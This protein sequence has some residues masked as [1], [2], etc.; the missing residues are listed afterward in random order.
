MKT[1][2]NKIEI[3]NLSK[4]GRFV[5]LELSSNETLKIHYD[6]YLKLNSIFK[7]FISKN[8]LKKINY[9]EE[10]F[11]AKEKALLFLS[12]RDHSKKEIEIKLKKKNFSEKIIRIAINYLSEKKYLDDR[13]FA[14]K[15]FLH[16]IENTKKSRNK[17]RFDLLKK[18]IKGELIEYVFKK[19][20]SEENELKKAMDLV[21]KKKKQLESGKKFNE[22]EIKTKIMAHLAYKGFEYDIIKK[23]LD[24]LKQN[25]QL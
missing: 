22:K 12:A 11:S 25:Q 6:I 2:N 9:E 18:G 5:F 21:L 15:Y 4:K 7:N 17:I 20:S 10:L 14:E 3:K 19:Y 16:A 24:V 1:E 8:D 13:K 23:A